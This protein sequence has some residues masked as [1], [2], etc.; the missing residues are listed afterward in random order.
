M[1]ENNDIPEVEPAKRG[2]PAGTKKRVRRQYAD[3]LACMIRRVETAIDLLQETIDA[4]PGLSRALVGIA[5]RT[6]K[7]EIS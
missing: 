5:V 1:S 4:E 7:G 6:L 3:E 2:R